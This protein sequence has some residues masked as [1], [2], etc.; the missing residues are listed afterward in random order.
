MKGF[1]NGLFNFF[2]IILVG[3]WSAI[4]SLLTGVACCI[5]LIGIP[6]GLQHFKFINLVFA[7]AGRVVVTHFG[8]HPFMNIFWLIFGGIFT[9]VAY[10][11]LG[12]LLCVTIVGIPLGLQL[13]KV[14]KFNLAP[15]GC[16]IV[17]AE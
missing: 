9:A 16:E 2:W 1:W 5:T 8:K 4:A 11:L 6:F 7:P 12:L 10:Y 13:F 17:K 3:I 15:F 14:A